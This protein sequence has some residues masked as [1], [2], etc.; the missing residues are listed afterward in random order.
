MEILPA[1]TLLLAI[2]G[3]LQVDGPGS[4]PEVAP[5]V[6]GKD[7]PPKEEQAVKSPLAT[8][9]AAREKMTEDQLDGWIATLKDEHALYV[10]LVQKYTLD[11]QSVEQ[12]LRPTMTQMTD[13][14]FQ[15]FAK[16]LFQDEVHWKSPTRP[17]LLTL[18]LVCVQLLTEVQ[19]SLD[20]AELERLHRLF[21]A[22]EK[23]KNPLPFNIRMEHP[24]DVKDMD[25]RQLKAWRD[26]MSGKGLQYGALST[27]Y[28]RACLVIAKLKVDPAPTHRL[29]QAPT[30]MVRDDIQERLKKK[31]DLAKPDAKDYAA[32]GGLFVWVPMSFLGAREPADHEAL[33][34]A[35]LFKKEPDQAEK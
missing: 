21:P 24:K 26:Y 32:I 16:T 15:A 2:L 22:G 31:L 13:R 6:S 33:I 19:A 9:P 35:G 30:S 5:V 34:R 18:T 17:E 29:A 12:G 10:E 3:S 23:P 27:S 28:S 25:D 8:A 20:D 7:E 14:K 4:I 11:A 1:M